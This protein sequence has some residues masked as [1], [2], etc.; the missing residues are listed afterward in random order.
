MLNKIR[1]VSIMKLKP[2]KNLWSQDPISI[3]KIP[4]LATGAV[5]PPN[6]EF[7]AVL[8]DQRHG[9][10]IEAPAELIKKMA[11]EA[12]DEAGGSGDCDVTVNVYLEGD[13]AGIVKLV[14]TEQ[15]KESKRKPLNP[16][17]VTL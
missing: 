12:I 17:P 3:P 15:I 5:I 4:R 16:K 13:A 1:N 6:K 2:F 10:N 11:K 8:G 7:L 14:K 9:Q